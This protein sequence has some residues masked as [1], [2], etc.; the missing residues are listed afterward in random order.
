MQSLIS[1]LS[2]N[3]HSQQFCTKEVEAMR[4]ANT[5]SYKAYLEEK[6]ENRTGVIRPGNKLNPIPLNKYLQKFPIRQ[7]NPFE[8]PIVELPFRKQKY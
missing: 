5:A 7:H 4:D 8:E 1:K 6:E 2:Q 3:E